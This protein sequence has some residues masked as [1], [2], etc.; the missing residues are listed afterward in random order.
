MILTATWL[1]GSKWPAKILK[2]AVVIIKLYN[3]IKVS[4]KITLLEFLTAMSTFS[5]L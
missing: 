5:E 3:T 1:N 2:V 4:V